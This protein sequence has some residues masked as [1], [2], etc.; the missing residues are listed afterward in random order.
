[1]LSLLLAALA[2]WGCESAVGPDAE[3]LDVDFTTFALAYP[4]DQAEIPAWMQASP[5]IQVT[6][7]DGIIMVTGDFVLP[8]HNYQPFAEAWLERD[9]PLVLQ[10][11]YRE[12][13]ACQTS[14]P[15]FGYRAT[16]GSLTPGTYEVVVK[17][18]IWWERMELPLGMTE[19]FRGSVEVP[20]VNWR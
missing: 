12:E 20:E 6:A 15:K 16:V 2:T 18:R 8:C 9:G 7:A 10:V 5:E 3:P 1:M 13:A 17:H 11:D 4:Q 19:V 14:T